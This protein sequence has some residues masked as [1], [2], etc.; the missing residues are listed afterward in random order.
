MKD[1]K[2][3]AINTN[4]QLIDLA[5]RNTGVNPISNNNA[6][7]IIILQKEYSNL[8]QDY[9]FNSLEKAQILRDLEFKNVEKLT[10]KIE[11]LTEV[12]HRKSK[13][14]DRN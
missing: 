5:I 4:Q 14:N 11:E 1:L 3:I 6:V 7:E 13:L 12:I 8:V 10:A 2:L 9:I